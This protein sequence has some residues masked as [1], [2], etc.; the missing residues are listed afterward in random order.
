MSPGYFRALH[1]PILAGD[2]CN[3]DPAAP[4][5]GSALVT[6]AFADRWFPGAD[7]IG[8]VITAQG[9]PPDPRTHITGV[10]GDVRENGLLKD[11]EPL[12]YYCGFNTYWPDPYFVVRT[13]STR[14]AAPSTSTITA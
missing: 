8:H 7:P 13:T 2:T 3:A 4:G 5:N 1:I 9:L 6:R 11:P 14:P 10:V 12:I